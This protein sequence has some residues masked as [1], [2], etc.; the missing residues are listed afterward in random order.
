MSPSADP[1]LVAELAGRAE[2]LLAGDDAERARRYPGPSAARQ[3]VHTAY[4]PADR[5]SAAT[6]RQW[7]EAA[8]QALAEHGPLPGFDE[9]EHRAVRA[10]LER[11]PIEDLR[12]DFEDGYGIRPDEAED[13]AA[14]AA[15]TALAELLAT[16]SAPPFTGLRIKSLEPAVRRRGLATLVL[17]LDTLLGRTALPAGFRITLP[18]VT[19]VLQVQAMAESCAVLEDRLGLA[20]GQ[21]RFEIQVETPQ[22]V[23]GPDGTALVAPMLTAAAGRCAGLHYGTYDYSASLG[24]AAAFQSLD[25]PAADHAKAVLQVAAAETGVPVSDGSTNVL[26]VGDTA[27]V[28]AAWRLHA[29]LVRR[30]LERGFYQGWDLHPAQ[31]PSRYA[32]TFRF[33]TDGLAAAQ[34]RLAA[35]RQ[36]LETGIA[37]EPATVRAL[38]DYLARGVACG[39]ITEQ[40]AGTRS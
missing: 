18:K 27:A 4:V 7:G 20:A 28:R 22:A 1:R 6:P 10:K 36:R 16:G 31:L 15:A 24:I 25:H 38:T 19:S 17:F 23:L 32:A 11:E 12:I 8:L 29:D 26:P 13:A 30:S 2:A 37:D 39:A 35:Y 14:V 5:F 33:F 40:Q 9:P 21:L 34:A 3:P